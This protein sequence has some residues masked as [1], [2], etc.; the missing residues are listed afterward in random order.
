LSA[1][2]RSAIPFFQ[3]FGPVI[4]ERRHV[5]P[6]NRRGVRWSKENASSVRLPLSTL[7]P[8]AGNRA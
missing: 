1:A 3:A 8:G 7:R 4:L 5:P 2:R 6:R